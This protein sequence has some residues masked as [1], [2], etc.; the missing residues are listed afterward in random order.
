MMEFPI[1]SPLHSEPEFF[2]FKEPKNRFQGINSARLPPG[3]VAWRAG[4]TTLYS[5]SVP[6]PHIDCLKI[7]AQV[8]RD[9]KSGQ[10]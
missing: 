4:T 8:P 2:N 5:Y 10:L 3:C 1:L 9:L 6:S 7:P